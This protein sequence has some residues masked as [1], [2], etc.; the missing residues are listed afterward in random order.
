MFLSVFDI[1]KVGVGPSSCVR[2]IL[3]TTTG[4][5]EHGSDHHG[6][7]HGG[8]THR[9]MVVPSPARGQ[10]CPGELMLPAPPVSAW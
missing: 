4:G 3:A 1:F 10:R 8:L 5:G 2:G 9:S 7:D 6:T